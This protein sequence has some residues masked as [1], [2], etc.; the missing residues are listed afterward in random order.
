MERLHSVCAMHTACMMDIEIL[1]WMDEM[2]SLLW[3]S[4]ILNIIYKIIICEITES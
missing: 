1:Q 2:E 4:I 3:W